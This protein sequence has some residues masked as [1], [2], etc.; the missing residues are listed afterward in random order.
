MYT[1]CMCFMRI[2]THLAR[3]SATLRRLASLMKLMMLLEPP[4][5]LFVLRTSDMIT[6]SASVP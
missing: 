4:V 3:D 1:V 2:N 5:V 6:T